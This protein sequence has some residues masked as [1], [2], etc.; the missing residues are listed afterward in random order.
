MTRFFII[1]AGLFASFVLAAPASAQVAG[2]AFQERVMGQER[3][4]IVIEE[5]I[6]LTCPHCADFY[7][8]TLPEIEKRYVK[9][10]KVRIILRD[11]PLDAVSLK[12]ATLA[13]CMPADEYYPF[14]H[15][16]YENQMKWATSMNPDKILV[17]YARLG[18]LDADR[19]QSCLNDPTLQSAVIAERSAAT[20]QYN[21]Q[22]T[23][24]FVFNNGVE[25]LEGASNIDGFAAIIDRMLA[26]KK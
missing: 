7:L 24:T 4:P 10:G 9:T 6:S 18:G 2:M 8:N 12:A 21:V 14:I 13:R 25:K 15:I 19:A 11:Y 17:Q 22:S 5:F 23:P 20:D 3:T 1:L 26:H 16:L